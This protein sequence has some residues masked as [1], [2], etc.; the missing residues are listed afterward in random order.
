[1]KFSSVCKY[2]HIKSDEIK[3]SYA[4]EMPY[5]FNSCNTLDST[6]KNPT[7]KRTGS[8]ENNKASKHKFEFSS[9]LNFF[10]FK[11]KKSEFTLSLKELSLCHKL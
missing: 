2:T 1:M 3:S 10:R 7:H 9:N 4:T 11:T 5:N 6:E 8:K